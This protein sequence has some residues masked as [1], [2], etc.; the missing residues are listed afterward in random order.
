LANLSLQAYQRGSISRWS[1]YKLLIR[2]FPYRG[3]DRK[4]TKLFFAFLLSN[5]PNPLNKA[6]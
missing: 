5:L 6:E 3:A 1:L 2:M 4:T